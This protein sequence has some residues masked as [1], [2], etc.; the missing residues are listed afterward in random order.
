MALRRSAHQAR[1]P[2]IYADDNFGDWRATSAELVQECSRA[3]NPG[4][5]F[6]RKVKPTRADCF[7]LKARNSAFAHW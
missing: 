1:V 3:S 7:V 5:R 6:T 2:N 4:A